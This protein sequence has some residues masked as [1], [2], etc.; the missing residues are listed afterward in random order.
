[1]PWSTSAVLSRTVAAVEA[2]GLSLHLLPSWYD[3]DT[4][5]DLERLA[6][7][8]AATPPARPGFPHR[9]AKVVAALRP[10]RG[11]PPRQELWRTLSSRRVYGNPWI[12]VEENVVDVG[13]GR[14]TLYGI[15]VCSGCVGVVPILPDG[16]VVMV[17][18]FRYVARRHTWE[19]P[20][21]GAHDGETLEEAAQRELREET[22]FRAGRLRHL[23]SIH[24]SKS[25]VDEV[26]HIFVGEDLQEAA[27]RPDDTEEIEVRPF[28]FETL[29]EMVRSGEIVDGMSVVG[30]LALASDKG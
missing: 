20:T 19:I 4:P 10:V 23:H 3:V 21:G 8:L 5:A 26:A 11:R 2:A 22:G 29:L 9:T 16:R 24:T 15:V 13:G 25:V 6:L 17:R 28:P 1:M 30:L 7:D 14:L 12:G 27:A 18:Q